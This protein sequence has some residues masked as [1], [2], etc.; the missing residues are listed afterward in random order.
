MKKTLL[1]VAAALILAAPVMAFHDD[2]VAHCNGC[3]TMHNS[4]NGESVA[5]DDAGN[6]ILPTNGNDFLLYFASATDTCLNCHYGSGSYHVWQEDNLDGADPYDE[7]GA[8][9]FS[10][11]TAPQILENTHGDF[12]PMDGEGAGHTLVSIIGGRATPDAELPVA[13][14][15][16]SLGA[17]E[18]DQLRCTSCHDAHFN[19]AFRALYR[20]GQ[21]SD[22]ANGVNQRIWLVDME[23]IGIPM[24]GGPEGN[25]NHNVYQDNYAQWCATCHPDV[26]DVSS[27]IHPTDFPMNGNIRDIYN[28]YTGSVDCIG[29][30]APCGDGL[31]DAGDSYLAQVPFEDTTR[32]LTTDNSGPISGSALVTCVTCHRAHGSSAADGG[33]WD[34]DITALEEDGVI[35]TTA[36][37]PN[38]YGAGQRSLCNKCHAKDEYDNLWV[39]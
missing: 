35:S 20:S 22:F 1:L 23:A 26:H 2:G 14:G 10:Y 18:S 31:Q 27:Q 5:F 12:Y 39:P 38:P 16:L 8:G 4:Q 9:D 11:S 28:A 33:R 32:T 17:Y 34:F 25:T 29:M 21:I 30:P 15:D 3:H 36:P 13:P 24:F 6:P 19:G 37:M 7:K